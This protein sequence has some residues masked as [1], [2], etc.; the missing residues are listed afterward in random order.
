MK[1]QPKLD[2]NLFEAQLK[3]ID[4]HTCGEFLRLVVDGMPEIKGSTMMERKNYMQENLDHYR[5]ALMDEPR[6]HK[7]MFGAILT[8]PIHKE[9]NYGVL[10]IEGE[11]YINMCGHGTIATSTILVETGMVPVTEPV[12]TV[13]LDVPAG[14][15]KAEVAVENGRAKE[16]TLT[17]IP[18]FVYKENLTT[19][20]DGKTYHYDISFGGD[21]FV[22]VDVRQTGLDIARENVE[23]LSKIGCKLLE[24]INREVTIK[25][26]TVDI[27]KSQ[28]C[29]FFQPSPT[30]G[31]DM[32]NMVA[33]GKN[34]ADRSPCGTGTCAKMALLYKHGEFKIGDTLVNESVVGSIFKG[35]I[36]EATKLGNY[37]AIIP[38][39][40]GTANITGVATYL[41]DPTD[42]FKY[43]FTLD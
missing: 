4:S 34:Q 20:L 21:F 12:T 29:E 15:V 30:P 5:R 2:M 37:D 18:A 33:F 43:G 42:Q 41:I 1:I 27:T 13:V 6:G 32:R 28:V 17:N 11:G 16:V 31:V 25:H 24:Q 3:A 26:P 14:M 7:N 36:K 38:Q 22:M 10:F 35:K 8:E 9:A 39:V 23:K 40:T 19:V